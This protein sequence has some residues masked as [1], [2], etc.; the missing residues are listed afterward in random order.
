[1]KQNMSVPLHQYE[2]TVTCL[3]MNGLTSK[4]L[5]ASMPGTYVTFSSL[6]HI[7]RNLQ[8]KSKLDDF[9]FW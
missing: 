5:A 1:M 8:L 9:L 7:L 3:Y 2:N 4:P 6:H